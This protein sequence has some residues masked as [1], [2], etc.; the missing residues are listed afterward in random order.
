ME[1]IPLAEEGEKGPRWEVAKQEAPGVEA[2][3]Q[4]VPGAEAE[5]ALAL[6]AEKAA[7]P[8][9]SRYWEVE[10]EALG[11]TVLPMA[12]VAV[13]RV[14]PRAQLRAVEMAV[15]CWVPACLVLRWAEHSAGRSV[16]RSASLMAGPK[17]AWKVVP[18]VALKVE[19]K[20]SSRAEPKAS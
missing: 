1:A 13:V 17:A 8:G 14:G 12:G 18:T 19:L 10:A 4:E 16:E 15:A 7:T 20:V 3:R 6:E 2:A 9:V 11:V 5:R